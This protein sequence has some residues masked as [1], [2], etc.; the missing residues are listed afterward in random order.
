MNNGMIATGNENAMTES[1]EFD[2]NNI[3]RVVIGFGGRQCLEKIIGNSLPTLRAVVWEPDEELYESYDTDISDVL[4]DS[5]LTMVVGDDIHALEDTLRKNIHE[6]N[7]HHLKFV[8]LGRYS[9]S[10]D[11]HTEKLVSMLGRILTEVTNDG[12]ARKKFHKLP[13]KNLIFTIASLDKNYV[14]SQLF[15][16]IPTRDVPIIIVSAGPSLMKNCHELKRAEGKAIILAVSHAVKT[17]EKAGIM[18]DLVAIS[19]AGETGYINSDYEKKYTLLSSV[20]ADS[21]CR[22]GYEGRIIYFGFSLLGDLFMTQRT[23]SEEQAELDT[24]SVATDVFSLFLT[25]GFKRIILVGQDLAY[26]DE[27]HSHTGGEYDE[28]AE[29]RISFQPETEG[30][31]GGIVK[32]RGDWECFRCFLE[33]KIRDNS[34][35]RVTDATEGGAL[36]HGTSIETLREAIDRY[37]VREYPIDVWIRCLSAGDESERNAIEQWFD[38]NTC[39]INRIKEQ[40]DEALM[41]NNDIRKVWNDKGKWDDGFGAS[42]RRYD[43]LYDQIINGSRGNLLR[44]YCIEDLQ[45]YLENALAVEG[46][47]NT[48][49]RMVMEYELFRVFENKADELLEY[50]EKFPDREG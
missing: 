38:E 41:L 19:D 20:Y 31:S 29:G 45:N 12:F 1:F 22:K 37:C 25:A 18:P 46:D 15:G 8:A 2:E 7:A 17:L 5:R 24:G 32:T 42:C 13:Y 14:I 27:G 33:E 34:N 35:V 23:R 26:D 44:L 40:L 16:N 11:P 28:S 49:K 3:L 48:E 9:Q 10:G 39:N 50:L 30:I 4:N 21:E 47:D 36:I 43:V 6:N